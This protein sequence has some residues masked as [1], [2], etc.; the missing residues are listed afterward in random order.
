MTLFVIFGD[1]RPQ[2]LQTPSISYNNYSNIREGFFLIDA[3]LTLTRKHY[4]H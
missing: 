4:F 3:G 1:D 2:K